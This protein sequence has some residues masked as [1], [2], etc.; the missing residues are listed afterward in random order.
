MAFG[1]GEPASLHTRHQRVRT[2]QTSASHFLCL[3]E[4]GLHVGHLDI[5]SDVTWVTLVSPLSAPGRR[6]LIWHLT[7]GPANPDPVAVDLTLH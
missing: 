5:D 6:R 4:G 7:D 1:V 3:Y 2:L